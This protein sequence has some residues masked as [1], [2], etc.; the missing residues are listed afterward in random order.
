[1]P[2]AEVKDRIDELESHGI[3][4]IAYQPMG[5]IEREMEMFAKAAGLS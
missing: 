3:T 4:E 5:D 1:L 2:E